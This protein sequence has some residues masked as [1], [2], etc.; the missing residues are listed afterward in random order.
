M[1]NIHLQFSRK[2]HAGLR[3]YLKR[4]ADLKPVRTLGQEALA[5]DLKILELARIHETSLSLE[6][7]LSRRGSSLTR[8]IRKANVFFTEVIT[9]IERTHR[10]AHEAA[11]HLNQLNQTL[12]KRTAELAASNHELK[13]EITRRA[14]VE[15]ALRKSE[16]HY[17]QLL[18]ESAR[19]QE[20]LRYLS[21]QILSTQEEERKKISRELHDHVAATLT[22][23]NIELN[24]LKSEVTG[25]NKTLKR[26]IASTQRLVRN[27]VEII[28][29]FA[30]ELR[31]ATLDDLGLIPALHSFTK[32]LSKQTGI[33]IRL[34]VFAGVED[35]AN[36]K[37][38]V[39]YRVTQEA[40]TNV[41]KHAGASQVEVDIGK[42]KDSVALSIKDNGKAFPVERFLSGRENKRLG[43]LGMRERV[44]M[45]GGRFHVESAPGKGTLVHAAVPMHNKRRNERPSG[46]Y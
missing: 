45:V 36:A 1:N 13:A 26:K 2:Y 18:E 16:Q 19:L 3:R 10:G 12:R 9:P 40:L 33:R 6:T 28:H 21:H 30:R 7:R 37:K 8:L 34:T 11:A 15:K 32:T 41:A 24:A 42:V 25:R 23:I 29:R 43:L 38:T 31:P 4:D 27:S 5:A 14:T 20:Q 22:G 39:L 46:D 44:E 17:S 35:L